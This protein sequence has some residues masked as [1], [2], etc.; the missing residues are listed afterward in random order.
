[1]VFVKLGCLR[2]LN[3]ALEVAEKWVGALKARNKNKK[4]G[5]DMGGNME[6]YRLKNDILGG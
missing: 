2:P 4:Q 1:M 6:P 3:T 5:L